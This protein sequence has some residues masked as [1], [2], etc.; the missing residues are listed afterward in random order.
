MATLTC[1]LISE[2]KPVSPYCLIYQLYLAPVIS[3]FGLIKFFFRPLYTRYIVTIELRNGERSAW[4]CLKENKSLFPFL[5]EEN[6]L[7][8]I[9]PI[10]ISDK[11]FVALLFPTLNNGVPESVSENKFSNQTL[12]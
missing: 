1:F 2:T 10:I 3:Y 5:T 11:F 12:F 9:L 6:I 8:V 7:Q 4:F